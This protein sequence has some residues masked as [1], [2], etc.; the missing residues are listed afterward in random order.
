MV[1][2]YLEKPACVDKIVVIFFLFHHVGYGL[3]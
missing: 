2:Y 1:I 3:E